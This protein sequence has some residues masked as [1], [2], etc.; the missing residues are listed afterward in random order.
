MRPGLSADDIYIMVEDEFLSTAKSFTQHLHQAEYKRL[1]ARAR[2]R[3]ATSINDISRPI[4]L[5]S[6]MSTELHLKKQQEARSEK[7]ENALEEAGLAEARTKNIRGEEVT[8]KPGQ[9]QDPWVGTHLQGLMGSPRKSQPSLLGIQAITSTT[10]AAAGLGRPRRKEEG[11]RTFDL[12]PREHVRAS[13]TKRTDAPPLSA[14]SSE[15]EADD[16]DL[17]AAVVKRTA[18]PASSAPKVPLPPPPERNVATYQRPDRDKPRSAET[19]SIITTRALSKS[20]PQK[21]RVQ[22]MQDLDSLDEV[23]KPTPLLSKRAL[24]KQRLKQEQHASQ[25]QKKDL[26]EIPL[27]LV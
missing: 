3:N 2:S 8:I 17:D 20:I 14:G 22:P 1:K 12:V 16:D 11:G 6:N 10:R 9:E 25:L 7:A 18:R 26:H 21:S 24:A 27:F 19:E 13:G 23:I 15:T 5:R 4:D